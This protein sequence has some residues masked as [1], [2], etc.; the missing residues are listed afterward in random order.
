MAGSRISVIVPALNEQQC[1]GDT[2][3]SLQPL[4]AREHEVIVVDG[5]SLDET[6]RVAR[7]LVDA[8]IDSPPG[9]ARQMA[10]GAAQA[11][12]DVI[13]FVHADTLVPEDADLSILD[14]LSHPDKAWGR[15]NVRLSG[16]QLLLR[17]VERMMNW[18]SCITGMCTGDQGIFVTRSVY[19]AI[20][21][22]PDQP[23]ME[24][25]ELSKRLRRVG[26]PVCLTDRLRTSSR[27][28]EQRGILRTIVRMWALRA[29]YAFG[30]DA[31]RLDRWYG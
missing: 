4:R 15:F 12:H 31:S 24:D 21:G 6:R 7:P 9:R 5:G 8:V 19:D 26:R 20:G 14:A 22:M 25:L 1:I 29:A 11:S 2:L 27:R 23:L 10:V 17:I 3:A 16:D 13:W 30:V 28:W 18:R